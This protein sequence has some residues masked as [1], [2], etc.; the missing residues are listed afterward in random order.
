MNP[1]GVSH[2]SDTYKM[3]YFYDQ[4]IINQHSEYFL[5][6]ININVSQ[7]NKAMA[8]MHWILNLQ[9]KQSKLQT[10]T[11]VCGTTP[12]LLKNIITEQYPLF[13]VETV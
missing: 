9:T 7:D 4:L 8:S 13:N 3:H 2:N 1:D 6:H 5:K 10:V 12:F 11:K